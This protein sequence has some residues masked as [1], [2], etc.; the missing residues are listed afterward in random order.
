MTAS[1]LKHVVIRRYACEQ[2]NGVGDGAVRGITQLRT[3]RTTSA[4][5]GHDSLK[6]AWLTDSA[7]GPH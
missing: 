2:G 5:K 7:R 1:Y 3:D 4:S 6:E